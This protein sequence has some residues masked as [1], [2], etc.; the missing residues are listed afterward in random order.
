M[1]IQANGSQVDSNVLIGGAV[2]NKIEK[3]RASILANKEGALEDC[4]EYNR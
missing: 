4:K 3:E 1:A 2:S